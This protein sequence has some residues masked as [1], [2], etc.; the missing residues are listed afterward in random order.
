MSKG[1][2]LILPKGT[3]AGSESRLRPLASAVWSSQAHDLV[4]VK[5][6]LG[7]SFGTFLESQLQVVMVHGPV[8]FQLLEILV[9]LKLGG[10]WYLGYWLF[11]LG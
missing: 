11:Q 8:D 10:F 7:C 4:V 3:A 1:T 6:L 5:F 2:L 9:D